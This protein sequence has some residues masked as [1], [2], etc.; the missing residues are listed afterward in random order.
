MICEDD[1]CCLEYLRCNCSSNVV[2]ED[3]WKVKSWKE[4]R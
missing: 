3:V 4:A 1:L 2:E